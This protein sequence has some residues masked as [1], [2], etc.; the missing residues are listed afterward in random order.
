MPDRSKSTYR[1]QPTEHNASL[2]TNPNPQPTS[3]SDRAIR[4][5]RL[6]PFAGPERVA[7]L[8]QLA[9]L[10]RQWARKTNSCGTRSFRDDWS[11]VAEDLIALLVFLLMLAES[12]CESESDE[13]DSGLPRSVPEL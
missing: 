4:Y 12:S 6:R 5:S 10:L 2:V 11:A 13:D 3:E 7:A 9:N 8:P 1:P